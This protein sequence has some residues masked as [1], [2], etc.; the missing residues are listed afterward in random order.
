MGDIFVTSYE[1]RDGLE[2]PAFVTLPPGYKNM[3]DAKNLPFII[4][5]HGGPQARDYAGFDFIAQFLASRGYGI[6]QMNF[7]GSDGYGKEF[8]EAGKAQWGQAMQDD[9]SDGV[10]WLIENG[11]AD[12]DRIAILGGSYGGYASL[13]GAMKTPE[14]YQCA[15]SLAGVSD[16]PQLLRDANKF[17]GG[18]YATRFVGSLWKDGSKLRENSPI[19]NIDK[20][21][22]P[23]LMFHGTDDRVVDVEQSSKFVK[24]MKRKGKDITYFELPDGD[25]HLSL[26]K[27]R[28]TFLRET[29]KFLKGCIG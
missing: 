4:Y 22:I 21:T 12:A 1:S 10:G 8:K 29:E 9:I 5:P 26:Y 7:R 15:I 24:A 25:H 13:V 3:E 16:L 14:L 17:S 23:V 19:N 27:N 28:L 20:Y 2:I 18:K 11:W 6:L